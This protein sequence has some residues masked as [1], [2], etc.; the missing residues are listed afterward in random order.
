[1]DEQGAPQD[2]DTELQAKLSEEAQ[3]LSQKPAYVPVGK[4]EVFVMGQRYGCWDLT[5][6][7]CNQIAAKYHGSATWTGG[8]RC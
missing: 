8:A 1:M 7:D 4:C 5:Q 2:F 6:N 3:S